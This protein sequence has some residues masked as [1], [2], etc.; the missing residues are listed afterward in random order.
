MRQYGCVNFVSNLYTPLQDLNHFEFHEANS[1]QITKSLQQN[2]FN[3]D[4]KLR[5]YAIRIL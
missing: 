4:A 5:F 2:N 3:T 1:L